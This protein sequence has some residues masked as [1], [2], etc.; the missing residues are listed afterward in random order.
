MSVGVDKTFHFRHRATRLSAVSRAEFPPS[1]GNLVQ[2]PVMC[3]IRAIEP[4]KKN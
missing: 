1:L 4:I 2:I 3:Q